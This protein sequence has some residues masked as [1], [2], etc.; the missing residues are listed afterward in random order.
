MDNPNKGP[1]QKKRFP[2]G[3]ILFLLAAILIILT[4]QNLSSEKG[5]KVSFSHQVEH[6]VNLDLVQK[7]ESRKTAQNDNLVTFTGKF[8]ERLSDD[9]KARYR[10]L[11]LL[12]QNH[13]LKEGRSDLAHNLTA[14]QDN[15]RQAGERFLTLSGL[16]IPKGG[17]TIVSP[18][19]DTHERENSVVLES[20]ESQ[21]LNALALKQVSTQV[22]ANPSSDAVKRFG[23]NVL[24][25]VQ[26]FRS[27]TLG[28]GNETMKQTLKTNEQNV[29]TTL[30][31]SKLTPQEALAQ[32][33][34]ALIAVEGIVA[35]LNKETNNVR[36]EGLRSVRNYLVDLEQYNQVIGSLDENE[37]ELSKARQNVADVTWFFNNKE[38]ST[39]A[40]ERQNPE[41][42]SLW[43]AHAK[44]EWEAYAGNKGA[45][46]KA[47]DQPRNLVLEK[48]F[49]SQEPS[50]NYFSYI[51]MTILPVVV[52]ILLLYFV[53]SRQMKGMGSNAM[54]F[55]KSPA[56]MLNKSLHKVT[57]K[58][59]AGV[60]EAKEE[61]HEIVDFLKDPSKFTALGARIPK[62]VLLIGPPGTGKTLIAKAVA[63][64]AD[65]PFFSIS[66]S[67]FVEMFVGVGA[68][69]IRDLFDQAKKNAPCIVFIDEIDAVGRHRGAGIGGG[70][71]EREQT[72]NQ[73]LVEM[74]GFDTNEGVILMAATNRPDVLDKALLRP[75]RFDRQVM[76]DL[77]DIKGRL[78]ILKVHA[79]KIK[80][81]DTVELMDIARAT[82]GTSGAD[83][84][85]ILNEAALLAA[86]KGRSAVTRDDTLEACDKVRYGK[87]R[88]SLELDKKE[89]LHT[90]YHE[91]GHAIV[92]LSVEH[93]DPVEKVTIIP[94]GFSLGATHFVPEKNKLS[95]WRKELVDR[96][97]VL[98]G[99][100]IAEDIFV[101]DF[102]SGAQ[103]DI[104]QATKLARSMVCQW[105]M[106]DALGPVAY[107]AN[108]E[109]GTYMAPGS[110]SK[111]YSDETAKQIDDEVR[112]LLDQANDRARQVILDSKDKVQLMTDM[113]MEFETLDKEDVHAIMDGKWDADKKRQKL[114]EMSEA[115]R[116]EPP[117][118][119]PRKS[120]KTSGG[121]INPTP[122]Q[123]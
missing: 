50:P 107:D 71:D 49:K 41:E 96:L 15:V 17:Y 113:L 64:E 59:V 12:D 116:K 29:S 110:S 123:I 119:P 61:L 68:S 38:L 117:P 32:Y 78:E 69:R 97:A 46:F 22:A 77:P 36:L 95:Y 1:E 94:R 86:R 55:G 63:G 2:G 37:A 92:G 20:T 91:S 108:G 120:E 5:G 103:M 52:I 100:R 48:T 114:K 23:I 104:S 101:G 21:E 51:L 16:P 122:Q 76:L 90:A 98:M 19:F 13:E 75:G 42:F 47:P 31:N 70:H 9:S 45:T 28:I 57:F 62:G 30:A 18:A 10:Y 89:K 14:L 11:E 84:M 8:K 74:D 73:L 6:L 54:N 66:G 109:E 102:S 111:S 82:P 25:L 60:E 43:F 3:F 72:L 67:D 121:D 105:G 56:R 88:K 27:P 87:E 33:Q 85:N 53:F 118:P 58:E 115:H 7:D 39:K 40:L 112:K 26:G 44:N 79:R 24:Q 4:V 35:E 106:N 80:L 93:A 81:D 34:T 99:G 65:R 83:L